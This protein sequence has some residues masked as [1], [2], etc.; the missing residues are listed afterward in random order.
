MPRD[1]RTCRPGTLPGLAAGVALVAL[2][3]LGLELGSFGHAHRGRASF[4]HWHLF[5]GSHT[6]E[7][8][9]R[10]RPDTSGHEPHAHPH[11]D[12]EQELHHHH[13]AEAAAGHEHGH[14]LPADTPR[15]DSDDE[16]T[17]VVAAGLHLP[18][19]SPRVAVHFFEVHDTPAPRPV[20]APRRAELLPS[21][22]R[23]PPAS[24]AVA[25]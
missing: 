5:A 14:D 8:S 16:Q 21:R 17:L 1:S 22:P 15:P 3:L 20:A 25:A 24:E 13:H 7:S 23:G 2:A 19:S 18:A 10:A 4:R 9:D 11:G 6:H 12:E